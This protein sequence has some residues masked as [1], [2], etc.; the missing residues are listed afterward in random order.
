MLLLQGYITFNPHAALKFLS[1]LELSSWQRI[2]G[3][4]LQELQGSEE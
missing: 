4:V 1:N 2:V 3:E